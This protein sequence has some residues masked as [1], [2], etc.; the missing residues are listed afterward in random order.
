MFIDTHAHLWSN[1]QGLD[2]LVKSGEVEQVWLMHVDYYRKGILTE[3][4]ADREILE[5]ARRYPG[6]FIP[7]GC[8]DFS[9]GPDRIDRMREQGFIGLK[10]IRPLKP[11]DDPAYL[12]IYERA[13]ALRMPV[14]FHV[15]IILRNTREEMTPAQSLGPTNM[16]PSMLDGIAAAFPDLPLIQGHMGFPWINELF[17]S[18]YYYPRIYCALCGSV[19]YRWLIDNLDRRCRAKDKE[20]VVETIC[21]RMMFATDACY[22]RPNSEV[23]LRRAQ[24][25]E[26]FFKHVGD[27]YQWGNKTKAVLRDN[28]RKIL[29]G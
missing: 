11:Y 4:A 16:R 15:G 7:F 24:F 17:E 9:Q 10:A 21:D 25:I 23:P 29:P 5:V 22:G 2:A 14:L 12:P 13:A 6:F 8:I 18:L 28:A 19:D 26:D 20:E 1:P 27:S 3:L